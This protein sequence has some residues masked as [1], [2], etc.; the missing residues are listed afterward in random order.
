MKKVFFIISG[1]IISAVAIF[2]SYFIYHNTGY[3]YHYCQN[4]IYYTYPRGVVDGGITYYGKDGQKIGTCDAWGVS[5]EN[6]KEARERAIV[7]N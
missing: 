4:G 2:A 1:I 7:C 3:E 5:G 6:C